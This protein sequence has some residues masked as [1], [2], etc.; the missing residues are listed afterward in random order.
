MASSDDAGNMVGDVIRSEPFGMTR[1]TAPKSTNP[2]ITDRGFT[3]HRENLDIG[4]VYMNARYYD[5]VQ[6]FMSHQRL[7]GCYPAADIHQLGGKGMS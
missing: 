1:G 3:G 2:G 7:D 6:T 4:L 5:P